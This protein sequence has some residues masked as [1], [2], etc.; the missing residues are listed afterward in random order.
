M[1]YVYMHDINKL[2][3]YLQFPQLPLSEPHIPGGK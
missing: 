1:Y 3:V 2:Y